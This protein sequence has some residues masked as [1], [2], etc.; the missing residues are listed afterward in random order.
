[1]L[2]YEVAYQLQVEIRA[3]AG[4]IGSCTA[5]ALAAAVHFDKPT[6]SPSRLFLYFN[7]RVIEGDVADDTGACLVDGIKV[8]VYPVDMQWMICTY[9]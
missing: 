6:L 1:M 2:L 7:E 9:P 4:K 8:R 3:P 5:N